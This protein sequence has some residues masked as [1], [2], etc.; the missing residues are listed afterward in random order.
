MKKAEDIELTSWRL[1]SV[2]PKSVI[3][4]TQIIRNSRN[5]SDTAEFCRED[6]SGQCLCS[7]REGIFAAS[8]SIAVYLNTLK[9]L[10]ERAR[11]NS[12]L[13]HICEEPDNLPT[14]CVKCDGGRSTMIYHALWVSGDL[15]WV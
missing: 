2:T 5:K 1:L 13:S 11:L 4:A 9:A 12:E 7:S 8:A 6:E 14:E 3:A 15:I 10:N